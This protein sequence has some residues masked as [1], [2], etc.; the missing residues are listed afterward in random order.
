MKYVRRVIVV[1]LLSFV[2]ILTA[3]ASGTDPAVE[4]TVP[5]SAASSAEPPDVSAKSVEKHTHNII[6]R[7]RPNFQPKM[8]E[9]F[10]RFYTI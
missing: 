9:F 4:P 5:V 7:M 2:L 6:I 10:S 8:Y 1:L 3:Y